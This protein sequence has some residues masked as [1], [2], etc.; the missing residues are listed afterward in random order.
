[1]YHIINLYYHKQTLSRKSFFQKESLTSMVLRLEDI[2]VEDQ[3]QLKEQ[4]EG[5]VSLMNQ[6]R[7]V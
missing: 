5:Q 1:M 4:L 7:K 6:G 2:V 3:S